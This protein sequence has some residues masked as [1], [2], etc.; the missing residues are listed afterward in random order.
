MAIQSSQS[1]P[2]QFANAI[3]Q[4]DPRSRWER[5]KDLPPAPPPATAIQQMAQ[6]IAQSAA[7]LAHPTETADAE[8]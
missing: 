3:K 5:E 2:D 4:A 8:E 6:D 7:R 1:R